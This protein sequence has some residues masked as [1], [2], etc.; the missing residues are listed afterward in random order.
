VHVSYLVQLLIVICLVLTTTQ[1]WW[2]IP[3]ADVDKLGFIKN[4]FESFS[5]LNQLR[6]VFSVAKQRVYMFFQAGRTLK[7]LCIIIGARG[8]KR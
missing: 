7:E 8:I 2:N 3:E 6:E 5:L 1:T 4:Q